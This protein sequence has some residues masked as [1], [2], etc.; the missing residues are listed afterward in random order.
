MNNIG[1]NLSQEEPELCLQVT[2]QKTKMEIEK[3]NLSGILCIGAASIENIDTVQV[4]AR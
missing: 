2:S 1:G 3:G 4:N